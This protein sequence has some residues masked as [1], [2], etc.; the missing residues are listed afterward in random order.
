[1]L[2]TTPFPKLPAKYICAVGLIICFAQYAWAR[3]PSRT[4]VD[5]N[6]VAHQDDNIL[7][8]NPDILNAVVAGHR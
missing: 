1:M 5:V 7:F 4:P 6:I 2:L 8:M 3:P